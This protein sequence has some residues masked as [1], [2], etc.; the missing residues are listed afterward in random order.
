VL[1]RKSGVYQF[2]YK[3]MANLTNS[4]LAL[5]EWLGLVLECEAQPSGNGA[6]GCRKH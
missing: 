6:S 2:M 1:D 4:S 3:A 5:Q